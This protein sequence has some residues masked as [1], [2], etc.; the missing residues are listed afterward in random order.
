VIPLIASARAELALPFDAL[1]YAR[2]V[3]EAQM[4]AAVGLETFFEELRT[5]VKDA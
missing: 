4:T 1:S 3:K 5:M 2:T